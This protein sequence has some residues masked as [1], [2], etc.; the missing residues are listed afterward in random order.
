MVRAVHVEVA[1]GTVELAIEGDGDVSL[2]R[3]AAQREDALFE[4]TFDR[5]LAVR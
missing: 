4:R 1:D 2:A 5:T 3:M